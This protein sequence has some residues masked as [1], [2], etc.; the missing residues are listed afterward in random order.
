[1]MGSAARLLFFS[2]LAVSAAARRFQ[3]VTVKPGDTLWAI[4]Q[5]YLKNPA[6]WGEMLKY[7]RLP[8]SDPT[9]ALPGMVLRVPV[10]LIRRDMLAASMISLVNHVDVRKRETA[11]WRGAR[12]RM[13]LFEG[14]ALRTLADSRAR[15]RFLDRSLLSVGPQSLAI[16]KPP[17][18]DYDV[19]LRRGRVFAGTARVVTPSARITPLGPDTK[20]L[21]AVRADMSTLVQVFSGTAAVRA[22]GKRV[23]VV[24]GMQSEVKPGLAPSMPFRIPN[25]TELDTEADIYAGRG[26]ES[27]R[28]KIEISPGMNLAQ[29]SAEELGAS[30]DSKDLTAEIQALKVGVPIAAYRLQASLRRDFSVIAFDRIYGSDQ[31]PDFA[32]L[33]LA[34]GI[35]WWRVSSIDL[36]GSP[37][38]F[39]KPKLY[40]I[41]EAVSKA[42]DIKNAW[43]L[44]RPKSDM[45]VSAD[46]FTV[47]GIL[48]IPDLQV[49]VNGRPARVGE[50]GNF[51]AEIDLKPGSNVVSVAVRDGSGNTETVTRRITRY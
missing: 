12:L 40:A 32:R 1:M 18:A 31:K 11:D 47:V 50:D 8:S 37:E 23:D 6:R 7:N 9:V 35:Y 22:Q 29:A 5:A 4:A 25:P 16:L 13:Q 48:K 14:D 28:A 33:G 2:F 19:N 3:D 20:Y 45:S 46:R 38:P 51:T 30:S 17:N 15:V 42:Y 49:S 44:V 41:G 34:P 39:S 27:G 43:V 36:L 10:D 21:A 26:P 24:A